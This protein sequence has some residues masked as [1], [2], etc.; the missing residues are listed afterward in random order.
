MSLEHCHTHDQKFDTEY[1][2]HCPL[3]ARRP[4]ES[5]LSNLHP[6]FQGIIDAHFPAIEG[7]KE[8]PC[9]CDFDCG[10]DPLRYFRSNRRQLCPA[11]DKCEHC[12]AALAT[13]LVDGE[14]LCGDCLLSYSTPL[15]E[16]EEAA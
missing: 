13:A 15:A 8:A 10:G 2:E 9:E 6:I 5:T 1:L 7:K 3:C 4:G 11:H 12:A 16:E 14:K